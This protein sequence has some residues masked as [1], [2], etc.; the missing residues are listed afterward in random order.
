MPRLNLEHR[1]EY[2]RRRRDKRKGKLIEKF[3]NKCQDCGGTF[4]KCA[5]DF[6]HINPLE[7]N[8]KLLQHLIVIGTLFLK[9]LISVLCC[10]LTATELGIIGKIEETQNLIVY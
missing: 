1:N 9:K 6:H 3:G 2:Q 7:K 10:V 4:H 5:Y 8:L